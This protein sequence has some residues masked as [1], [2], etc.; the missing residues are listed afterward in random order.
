MKNDIDEKKLKT[1]NNLL[2]IIVLLLVSV[3]LIM[4]F[5][6]PEEPTDL[7]VENIRVKNSVL[8][9]RVGFDL[10][11]IQVK[12]SGVQIFL[13]DPSKKESITIGVDLE[14]LI[15]IKSNEKLCRLEGEKILFKNDLSNTRLN[16]TG[17]KCFEETEDDPLINLGFESNKS[18]F[19]KISDMN[20][21][22]RIDINVQDSLSE[23]K[24][25]GS[26]G[27][28]AVLEVDSNN[29][30]QL[31]LASKDLLKVKTIKHTD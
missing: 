11:E 13:C 6:K 1:Q 31:E 9:G 21:R 20:N 19:L 3:I 24:V 2:K 26:K 10:G 7:I 5:K 22:P 12:D 29:E 4:L 14:G 25:R 18:S 27:G 28:A 16:S 30:G 17:L 15:E 23:V 8:F